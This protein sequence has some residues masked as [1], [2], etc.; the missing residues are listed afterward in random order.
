MKINM[1]GFCGHDTNGARSGVV[2]SARGSLCEGGGL[3]LIFA[4]T[5]STVRE[6][7]HAFSFFPVRVQIHLFTGRKGSNPGLECDL[8]PLLD[9]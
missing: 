5:R 8:S 4:S 2:R 7:K 1:A 6:G 3:W 9:G